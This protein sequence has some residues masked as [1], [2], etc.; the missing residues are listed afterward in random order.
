[1]FLA[2][3]WLL[4]MQLELTYSTNE[5]IHR[6]SLIFIYPGESPTAVEELN[7]EEVQIYFA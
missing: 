7:T 6:E 5:P 1:M 3:S 4:F 2:G